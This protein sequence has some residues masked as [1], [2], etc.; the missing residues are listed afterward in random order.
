M[1]SKTIECIVKLGGSLLDYP[2]KLV[3]LC[4]LL[5]CCRARSFTVVPGG[6]VFADSVRSVDR[7]LSLPSSV[8]HWM[9][10]K[11]MDIYGLLLAYLIPNG[12]LASSLSEASTLWLDGYT[13]VLEVYGLKE[14][15]NLPESWDVSSDSIALKLAQDWSIEKLILVKDVDGIYSV[16]P[17]IYREAELIPVVSIS[18]LERL[19]E[20]CVD[21]FFPKLFRL[22]PVRCVIVNGLK[23]DMIRYALEGK[24]IGG[25]VITS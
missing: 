17:K 8:S 13:P 21:R 19:G 3:E 4:R 22:K 14:L 12:R 6:G 23:P 10:I 7:L 18:E 9:A 2:D 5:S 25:T 16:D 20:T 15:R 24:N 11:S 1:G